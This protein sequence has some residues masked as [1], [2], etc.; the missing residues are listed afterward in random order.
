MAAPRG[1][2][3]GGPAR[4]APGTLRRL[5]AAVG[6]YALLL[7]PAVLVVAFVA[8]PMVRTALQSFD[9]LGPRG[10]VTGFGGL[11]N[12]RALF[13]QPLFVTALKNTLVFSAASV[14]L[15][16]LV[17]FGLAQLLTTRVRAAQPLL[18]AIFSPTVMPMIAAA[19]IWLYFL[20]PRIGLFG[21]L[22]GALGIHG[23]N[24]LGEPAT[25]LAVLVALFVWKF[26]PYF[27]LFIMAGLQAIPQSVREALRTED[28]TGWHA[29]RRVVLPMLGPMLAFVT[30]MA[31]LYAVE[32]VDP[33]YVLTQGGPDNGTNL[34]MFYLYQLGFNYFSWGPAAALSALLMASLSTL[35][36]LA[37]IGLERRA[38][39]W[40]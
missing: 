11:G 40:R 37:L 27:A 34:L 14:V 35:S 1:M 13:A 9:R 10:Q 22:L 18:V 38:F 31:L 3:P 2:T 29:F 16:V 6:P 19:N 5:A 30:T 17:A 4:P 36:G 39:H 15:C 24:L 20:A 23:G 26:A 8:I 25:A 12:Y 33:V 7:L 21:R 32:T 28:P